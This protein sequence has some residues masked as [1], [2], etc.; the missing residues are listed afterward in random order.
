MQI[1]FLFRRAYGQKGKQNLKVGKTSI[2][3]V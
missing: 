3:G 2:A 1:V